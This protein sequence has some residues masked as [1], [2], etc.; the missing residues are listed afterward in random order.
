[1]LNYMLPVVSLFF[2]DFHRQ[3]KP[4][5]KLFKA[6]NNKILNCINGLKS[7][8]KRNDYLYKLRVATF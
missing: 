3:S 7:R 6:D 5:S 2:K 4:R 8:F 1:M